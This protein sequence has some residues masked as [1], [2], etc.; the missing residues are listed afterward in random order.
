MHASSAGSASGAP[1]SVSLAPVLLS[2]AVACAGALAFGYHL[3]VVNGP[4]DAISRDL[5]IAGQPALQG[6]V[7]EVVMKQ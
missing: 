4:L 6:L 5:A 7:S 1:G 3:G 2:V